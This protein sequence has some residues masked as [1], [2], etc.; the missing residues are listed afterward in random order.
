LA[1]VLLGLNGAACI[2]G[3]VGILTRSDLLSMGTL[4]GGVL[5]LL[6]LIPMSALTFKVA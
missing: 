1:G 6:A 2:L 3:V 5:F 4:A